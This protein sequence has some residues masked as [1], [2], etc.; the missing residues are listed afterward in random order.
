MYQ[1]LQVV[2]HVKGL[3]ISERF[4]NTIPEIKSFGKWLQSKKVPLDGNTLDRD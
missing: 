1:L 2:D 3:L 4:N